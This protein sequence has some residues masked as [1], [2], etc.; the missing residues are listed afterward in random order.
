MPDQSIF[1]QLLR[2]KW[3]WLLLLVVLIWLGVS[4]V[5]G[6]KFRLVSTDPSLSNFPVAMP[7]LIVSF[8]RE[9]N[10]KYS[11]SSEPRIIS[12]QKVSGKQL[13]LGLSA[14]DVSQQYKITIGSI[15]SVDGSQLTNQVLVFTPKNIS[16]GKLS[17]EHQQ[18]ILANQQQKPGVLSL[19]YS[20]LDTLLDHGISSQQ[21]DELQEA[22]HLYANS[23]KPP[24]KEATVDTDS[25]RRPP[26]DPSAD[27]FSLFFTLSF[28][29]V[30]Y[31][32]KIEYSG[33]TFM[34]LLLYD[35]KTGAQVFDSFAGND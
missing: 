21:L 30:S 3:L 24:T 31:N 17:K 4:L 1:R 25:L 5:R 29:K 11:I 28:D 6:A 10:D 26:R 33:L 23:L 15:S 32:A 20:G 22:I 8:N 34:R 14:L 19:K 35:Q 27:V 2:S 18:K 9:L 12:D 7:E 16:A 13:I